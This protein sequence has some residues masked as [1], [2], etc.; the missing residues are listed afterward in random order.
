MSSTFRYNIR[1]ELT[2]TAF[3]LNRSRLRLDI[4]H[5]SIFVNRVLL[6]PGLEI[7]L[8]LSLLLDNL[9]CTKRHFRVSLREVIE[10]VLSFKASLI[11]SVN[12]QLSLFLCQARF[13]LLEHFFLPLSPTLRTD[14]VLLGRH[15]RDSTQLG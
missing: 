8:S 15:S 7:I 1:C 4:Y 14:S 6:F 13:K 11:K 2:K 5:L 3:G 9:I 10:L 12:R